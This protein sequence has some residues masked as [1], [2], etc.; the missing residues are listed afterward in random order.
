MKQLQTAKCIY[1]R[2]PHDLW[3]WNSYGMHPGEKQ[4]QNLLSERGEGKKSTAQ[5]ESELCEQ[6]SYACQRLGGRC[7]P[8]RDIQHLSDLIIAG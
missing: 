8:L 1:K 6:V 3:A 2:C 5:L 7:G 4:F